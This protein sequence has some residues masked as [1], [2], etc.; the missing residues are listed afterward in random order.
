MRVAALLALSAALAACSSQPATREADPAP[1]ATA[2]A[3]EPVPA[4]EAAASQAAPA[5]APAPAAE[6][7]RPAGKIP[8]GYRRETRNGK[9]LFCRHVTTVGSRFPQKTCFTREQI[10]E[11][12]ERTESAMDDFEQGMKVCGGGESCGNG[13]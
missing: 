13:N 5:A 2:P 1:V 12:Q 6:S 7:A 11:I 8:S 9:E 4:P 10:Q 3:S